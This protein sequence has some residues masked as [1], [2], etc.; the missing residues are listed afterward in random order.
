MI[1]YLYSL[2]FV[3]WFLAV[4]LFHHH[5]NWTTRTTRS[6]VNS[7]LHI[8]GFFFL[9]T[10]FFLTIKQQKVLIISS[11]VNENEMM[12]KKRFDE[13]VRLYLFI[14]ELNVHKVQ[15]IS[16]WNTIWKVKIFYLMKIQGF[17][18]CAFRITIY[19]YI[20]FFFPHH[21]LHDYF[22]IQNQIRFRWSCYYCWESRPE[23]WFF[24]FFSSFTTANINL[25]VAVH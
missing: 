9:F 19:F 25:I 22:E 20:I 1:V 16:V 24:I 10:F 6:R 12:K 17:V 15:S 11:I 13:L 8:H 4:E 18:L 2:C 7:L 21:F 3:V 5:T 23:R 14:P